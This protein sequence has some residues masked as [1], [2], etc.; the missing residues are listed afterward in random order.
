MTKTPAKE[1]DGKEMPTKEGDGSEKSSKKPRMMKLIM[2]IK[3]QR[4]QV[5]IKERER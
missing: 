5:K 4:R 1:G 3:E 2:K